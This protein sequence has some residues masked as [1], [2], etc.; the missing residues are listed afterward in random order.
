M[1][2]TDPIIIVYSGKSFRSTYSLTP[3]TWT[4][5]Y[6]NKGSLT[7]AD[8][9]RLHQE[10]VARKTLQKTQSYRSLHGLL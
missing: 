2:E 10:M 3:N 4:F 5:M 6:M 7:T 9:I 1:F 8:I